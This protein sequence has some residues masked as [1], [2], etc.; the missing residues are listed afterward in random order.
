MDRHSDG[1]H[2]DFPAYTFKH[3]MFPD[4][5]FSI[6]GGSWAISE[7]TCLGLAPLAEPIL[8]ERRGKGLSVSDLRDIADEYRA[9]VEQRRREVGWGCVADLRRRAS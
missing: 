4:L 2:G 8:K 6:Y 9:V 1:Y 7:F 3:R 5:I